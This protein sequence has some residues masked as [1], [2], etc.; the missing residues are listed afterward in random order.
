MNPQSAEA[1]EQPPPLTKQPPQTAIK[2]PAEPRQLNPVERNRMERI[3]ARWSKIGPLLRSTNA[4][5]ALLPLRRL[6]LVRV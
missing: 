3:Q 4:S 6:R 2:H 1:E 5:A